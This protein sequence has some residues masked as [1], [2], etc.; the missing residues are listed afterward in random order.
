MFV[1]TSD[2]TIGGYRFSAVN[3]V[4]IKRS[5][6]E[7]GATATIKVP[8]T[9]L[10]KQKKQPP[11]R[12]NTAQVVKVGDE[13]V[14]K[15]GYNVLQTEFKGYVKRVNFTSPIEIE[16]EDAFYLTRS[17]N[18]TLSGTKKLEEVLQDCG[19]TVSFC[20][21]L[22]MKNFIAKD[23]AVSKVLEKLKAGYGLCI[24]FDFEGKVCA[25]RPYGVTSGRKV[26]Y[27]LRKN[28]ISDDDLKYYRKEDNKIYIKA[29]CFKID[30]TKVEATRGDTSG[31]A[32]TLSFYD[33]ESMQELAVMAQQELNRRSYDGYDGS[34]TTFLAPFV[35]PTDT[36]S[37]T[38]PVYFEKNGDY[39]VEATE[40]TFGTGGARRKVDIG[41]KV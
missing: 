6:Y 3:E 12:L 33:I 39:Y 7:I 1:L 16:C 32:V 15:L 27:T 13:V 14:I 37:I 10:L 19:L 24:F 21:S 22:T 17:R 23:M 11:A 30:G 38:D 41:I 2:I 40:V 36:A 4:V 18:V 29:V 35:S 34:I 5:I 9:A 25:C 26:K 31:K 20:E 28:V 8:V